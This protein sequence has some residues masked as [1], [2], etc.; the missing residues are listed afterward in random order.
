VPVD[1]ALQNQKTVTVIL[2]ELLRRYSD[3]R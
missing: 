2:F 1:E 3:H